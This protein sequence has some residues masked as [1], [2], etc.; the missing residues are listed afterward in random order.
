MH[1]RQMSLQKT[2]R[3][4]MKLE[5]VRV[6]TRVRVV[7]LESRFRGQIGTITLVAPSKRSGLGPDIVVRFEQPADRIWWC[8]KDL[9]LEE[10]GGH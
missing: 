4:S 9:A 8:A 2:G 6:G 7:D 1:F 10:D 5:D 3:R